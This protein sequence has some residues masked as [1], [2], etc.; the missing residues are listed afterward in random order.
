MALDLTAPLDALLTTIV[1]IESVSGHERA[2]ADAVAAALAD[3]PHLRVSRDGDAVVARTEQGR[4]VRVAI[5]GHLDTV[6]VKD[7]LPSWRVGDL[8]YGRGTCD[9]KGGV[10]VALH[11]AALLDAPRHD[12]TWIFYDHEEVEATKNG[13]GR[14]ARRRPELLDADFAILMEPTSARVEGGCQGTCRVE[15][16]T[17]G[18]TAHSARAW[19]GHNAIH[20]AA[21]ILATLAAYRPRTVVVDA[22]EYR[23]GLN[24][25]DIRGGVAKNTIPDACTVTINFRFAPDRDE[26]SV[27]EHLA[28]VFDG[29]QLTYTDFSPAARPGL[30]RP[31]ARDF[32]DA[33]GSQPGPKY[34]WTDVARFSA[35]G[36]PA[37]NYGPGDPGLAHTD[38]EHTPVADLYA[39]AAAL[40][41][42]LG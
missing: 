10:A 2:L 22:L 34:G 40:A 25:V 37:V 8:I 42:W 18:T 28:Q 16:T 11:L 26:A 31:L 38:D 4:P 39:C 20:D 9:M 17:T 3:V 27:R 5:A 41:R 23:E 35:L 15:I 29:Y 1:D 36:I 13:L 12:I 33:V 32:L 19:L 21:P 7:N 6:P 14:L 30:D 24:A